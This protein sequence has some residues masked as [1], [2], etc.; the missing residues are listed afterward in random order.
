MIGGE[1]M[2]YLDSFTFPDDDREAGFCMAEK[3]TCYTSFYPFKVP[4]RIPVSAAS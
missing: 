2:V 1:M 3:R 4:S